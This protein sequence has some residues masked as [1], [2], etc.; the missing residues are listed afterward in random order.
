MGGLGLR[1]AVDHAPAAFVASYNT[2][3]HTVQDI[4]GDQLMQ[5]V[6]LPRQLR[7]FL[8]AAIAEAD[9]NNDE[10]LESYSQ[11]ALSLKIDL[12]NQHLYKTQV[13]NAGVARERARVRSINL[14]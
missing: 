10:D 5:R 12:Q 1:S 3:F 9:V 7:D 11:K 2:T 4:F 13:D 6:P 8:T 14:P